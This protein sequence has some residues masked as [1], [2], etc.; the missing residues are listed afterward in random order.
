M[1]SDFSSETTQTRW[2]L[3][4]ERKKDSENIFK[5]GGKTIT[6]LDKPTLEELV[7]SLQALQEMFKKLFGMKDNDFEVWIYTKK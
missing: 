1:T 5:N 3:N 7:S 6:L 2:F 4:A